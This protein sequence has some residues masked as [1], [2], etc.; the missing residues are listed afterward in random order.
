MQFAH[1]HIGIDR[2]KILKIYFWLIP[3]PILYPLNHLTQIRH[4]FEGVDWGGK[5]GWQEYTDEL[6]MKGLNYS[7][8][9][10]G[11]V[12][13]LEPDILECEVKWAIKKHYHEQS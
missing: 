12:T 10:D 13:H 7:D 4:L 11:V 3:K 8:N 5:K 2:D 1:I 6:Y 9:Y